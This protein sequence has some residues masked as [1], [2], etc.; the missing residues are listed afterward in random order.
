MVAKVQSVAAKVDKG[1]GSAGQLVN[2]PR[3]YESLVDTS[4]GVERDRY[5][6]LKRLVEQWEKEGLSVKTK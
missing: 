1:E 6:A 2:D 3:L 4:R 5:K